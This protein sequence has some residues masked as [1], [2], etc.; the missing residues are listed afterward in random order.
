MTSTF[1]PRTQVK[2]V[3][4]EQ[5]QMYLTLQPMTVEYFQQMLVNNNLNKKYNYATKN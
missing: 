5:N 4:M 3:K 1:T 2:K